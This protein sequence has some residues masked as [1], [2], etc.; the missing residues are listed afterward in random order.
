MTYGKVLGVGLL[1]CLLLSGCGRPQGELSE[2]EA[3]QPTP[4]TEIA[5]SQESIA[6]G[7]TEPQTEGT[8]E[9]PTEQHPEGA[10]E[11]SE[12]TSEEASEEASEET[13]A[14]SLPIETSQV[15]PT[16][17]SEDNIDNGNG[18]VVAIDAGHQGKGNAEKEPVGPGSTEMKA[19]VAS[20]TQGVATG[21]PEYELTLVISLA[22][23]EELEARGYEI[24]MIRESHDV[25]ISNKERAEVANASG[26]EIFLRIHA[27]GA[28]NSEVQGTMTLCN[29]P[30]NPYNVDIYESSRRLS[31]AVLEHMVSNMGSKNRGVWETDT[32]TG[33]NWS[34]VP[35]TIIE[36]GFMTNPTE[37]QLIASDDYQDKIVTG[38]ADGLDA[39]FGRI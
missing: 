38:I 6:E 8:P 19:K 3:V 32:M 26:A 12:E 30:N 7:S 20:G 2:W 14:E 10:V 21:V 13:S 34:E 15:L 18:H 11:A 1:V 4:I 29:T 24:V 23:K 31:D 9:E 33:I 35:V 28:A 36:M 25:N 27:N 37:D 22:L 16:T 17:A 39:Y 5:L